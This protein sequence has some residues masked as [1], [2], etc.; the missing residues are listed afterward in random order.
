MAGNIPDD[1]TSGE[2]PCSTKFSC[3]F[4]GHGPW[5]ER[6][7]GGLGSRGYMPLI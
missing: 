3:A 2:L 1:S 5:Q 7:W 6:N 4:E